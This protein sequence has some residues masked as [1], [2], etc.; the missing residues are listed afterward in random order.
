MNYLEHYDYWAKNYEK[1]GTITWLEYYYKF[2]ASPTEK[3]DRQ[4]NYKRNKDIVQ[5]ESKHKG[6]ASIK[7]DFNFL[8]SPTAYILHSPILYY[9]K[10]DTNEHIPV[11]TTRKELLIHYDPWVYVR[12]E[13]DRN[14][15][16]K[17]DIP[18][19]ILASFPFEID[20]T[21]GKLYI[22]IK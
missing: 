18:N 5:Q 9:N 1:Q 10:I 6:T 8:S 17:A 4:R 14:L 11:Y 7:Y 20:Y 2:V 19:V 16:L 12:I 13:S 22:K 3:E 15:N 21:T